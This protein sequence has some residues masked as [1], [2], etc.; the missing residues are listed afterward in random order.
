[1]R[2]SQLQQNFAAALRYQVDASAC[3]INEGIFDCDARMQVYRNNFILSLSEVLGVTY[4]KTLLLVGEECFEQLARNHILNH[5]PVSGDVNDYGEGFWNVFKDFPE[6][7][8]AAPYLVDVARFEWLVES[9]TFSRDRLQSI[10]PLNQLAHVPEQQHPNIRLFVHSNLHSYR[11]DFAV[12]DLI[13][14]IENN[15]FDQLELNKPQQGVVAVSPSGRYSLQNLSREAVQLLC[16]IEAEKTLTEIDP[17][18]LVALSELA[19]TGI[20]AGYRVISEEAV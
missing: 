20:L 17:Q 9:L 11:S 18:R 16:D 5:P 2:L 1:M 13:N 4:N 10:I 19:Q 8:K 14:A 12:F 3:D 6:I 7:I 15:Q